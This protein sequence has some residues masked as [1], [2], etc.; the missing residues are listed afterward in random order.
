MK[1]KVNVVSVLLVLAV[2]IPS[3]MCGFPV[4]AA[5]SPAT[6][7]NDYAAA[8]FAGGDGTETSPYLISSAE[9]LAYLS[10]YSQSNVTRD[11]YFR[12]TVPEID[13]DAHQWTPIG[14]SAIHFTGIFDGNGAVV[15]NLRLENGTYDAAGCGMFARANDATIQNL[16]LEVILAD[17]TGTDMVG[18]IVGAMYNASELIDCTV[19]VRA[20]A[21]QTSVPYWGGAVGYLTGNSVID[22]VNVYGTMDIVTAAGK[23]THLGGVVGRTNTSNAGTKTVEIRNA[24]NY[25]D[26]RY[27]RT[28]GGTAPLGGI[29]GATLHD[30]IAGTT[31][32]ISNCI[33]YGSLTVEQATN[34]RVG[35][36]VGNGGRTSKGTIGTLICQN[37]VNAGTLT[38]NPTA[39]IIAYEESKETRLVNCFSTTADPLYI[40]GTE[41]GAAVEGCVVGISLETLTGARV[42]IDT[43]EDNSSGIRF[44]SRL[45]KELYDSLVE[46]VGKQAGS[47]ELGTLIA[48]SANIAAVADSRDKIAALEAAGENTYV[49]VPFRGA[50]WVND[51]C[52]DD[53]DYDADAYYYSGALGGIYAENFMLDYT[54]VGYLS[55]TIGEWSFTFYAD[56]GVTD[57]GVSPDRVRSVGYVGHLAYLD[58]LENE[59]LYSDAQMAVL[60]PYSDAYEAAQA[61]A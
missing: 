12:V 58:G 8:G 33:N 26:I 4:F 44:D 16:T 60:K 13:L 18:T 31:T 22:G 32:K 15:R 10:V 40:K 14:N 54:A 47:V 27:V 50:A 9:E 42:R 45:N 6:N 52:A 51:Q 41:T 34:G 48:P 7:W 2:L 24:V 28:G 35:G 39:S 30:D 25:A 29:V 59:G 55:I 57:G 36:I 43:T 11:K 53:A 49:L 37:C 17:P 56:D 38:G 5:D 46:S 23:E 3:A 1:S 61:E 21:S 19:S 20:T